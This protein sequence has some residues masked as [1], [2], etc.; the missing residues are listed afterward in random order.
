MRQNQ[1][2]YI[3]LTGG[4]GNISK[5]VF[6]VSLPLCLHPMPK[7]LGLIL[8]QRMSK[9]ALSDLLEKKGIHMSGVKGPLSIV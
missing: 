3:R 4:I 1:G 5:S 9:S 8:K 6:Y 2:A 7:R